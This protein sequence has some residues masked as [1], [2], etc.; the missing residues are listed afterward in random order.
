METLL[1]N[2]KKNTDEI[3]KRAITGLVSKMNRD[4]RLDLLSNLCEIIY[5]E[6]LSSEKI[7][8]LLEPFDEDEDL[9]KVILL[10]CRCFLASKEEI[11]YIVKNSKNISDI[12]YMLTLLF[13]EKRNSDYQISAENLLY[14][15]D[16]DLTNEDIDSLLENLMEYEKDSRDYNVED[17]SCY[18]T[19]KKV[20]EREKYKCPYW[21]S[22]EEGENIGLLASV[23]LG[24]DE[25]TGEEVKF[26][27]IIDSS[28]SFFY[29]LL[30]R[31]DRYDEDTASFSI[32]DLPENIKS[33]I[34]A[35]L[36]ASTDS[37]MSE[38]GVKIGSSQRVWGPKN[39]IKGLG[40]CSGPN[41]EG[42]C[43]MLQCECIG[44]GDPEDSYVNNGQIT[45]FKGRCDSCRNYIMDIS[46]AL[47]FPNHNGGW[48]GCYCCFDCMQKDPPHKITKEENILIGIMK[49]T[50]DRE[51][52]MDRSSFC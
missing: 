19:N 26:D 3:N 8:S 21:V 1:K 25:E 12:K 27:K 48:I 9:D 42:P 15:Y 13:D 38:S 22:K 16:Y 43:R 11:K 41:G 14:C 7:E 46:H 32:T 44:P 2:I 29:E 36:K 20:F 6:K 35:F 4:R 5:K 37:E 34:Q 23:P 40:C 17:I 31:K 45:W 39:D 47:R 10:I 49:E 50:I 51:G 30:P 33:S 28:S 24:V 52:I 18:L